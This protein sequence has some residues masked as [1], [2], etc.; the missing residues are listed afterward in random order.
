MLIMIFASCSNSDSGYKI[1]SA[2]LNGDTKL[3]YTNP[4]SNWTEGLPIGNGIL[5]IWGG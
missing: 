1:R 2:K 5:G 3:L 4:A